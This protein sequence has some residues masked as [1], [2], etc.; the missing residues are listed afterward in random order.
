MSFGWSIS[1]SP[2]SCHCEEHEVRRSN[3]V[4][5]G[6]CPGAGLLRRC[7]PR[8]D[9]PFLIGSA[10]FELQRPFGDVAFAPIPHALMLLRVSEAFAQGTGHG[11]PAAEVA[12]ETDLDPFRLAG[13]AFGIEL[14]EGL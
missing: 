11:R 6:R 3:L 9:N 13:D 1:T 8:N 10:S 7:A 4:R 2:K 12:V 14:V 5:A